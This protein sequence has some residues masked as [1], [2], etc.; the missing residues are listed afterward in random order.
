[1]RENQTYLYPMDYQT[2]KQNNTQFLAVTSLLPDE[3]DALL[4]L[5]APHWER[6]YRYRTL[7]GAYRLQ[8][9]YKEHGNATLKTTPTKLL[10]LLTYL[11]TNALQQSQALSF[12]I[13]QTK[14]SR[15]AGV[16]LEILNQTLA[17][18]GLLPIRNAAELATSLKNHTD[19]VFTYDG[20]ER[21]IQRNADYSAQ[22]EEY[23]E[24]KKGIASRITFYATMSSTFTTYH[25]LKGAFQNGLPKV[26]LA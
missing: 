3:F 26:D 6:Y 10:F 17:Q 14:V 2:L 20:L 25:L 15:M 21:A 13:S 9:I 8:P 11:K 18:E 1:M 23:S 16:L 7:T 24:K 22:E 12:G 4:K 5:F 19:K